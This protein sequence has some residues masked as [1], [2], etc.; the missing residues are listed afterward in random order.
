MS[1][2]HESYTALIELRESLDR[3][4]TRLIKDIEDV[5]RKLNAVNTTIAILTG[6][7]SLPLVERLARQQQQAVS[8][9][10][11]EQLHGLTQVLA[12]MRI[13]EANNGRFYTSEAKRLLLE[14]GLMMRTKNSNNILFSVIN[15]SGKF[16]RVT[17][18]LYEVTPEGREYYKRK[19]REREAHQPLLTSASSDE[20]V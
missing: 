6:E 2:K 20:E 11:P 4:H 13:A 18:G 5:D 9:V 19:M 12:L 1:N 14:S 3:E 16:R 7:P 15:R 8:S 17:P 10:K